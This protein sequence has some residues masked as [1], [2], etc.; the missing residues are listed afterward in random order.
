MNGRP[1]KRVRGKLRRLLGKRENG[2]VR[3]GPVVAPPRPDI[4]RSPRASRLGDRKQA[5][6][7]GGITAVND[8]VLLDEDGKLH[9]LNRINDE[10]NGAVASTQRGYQRREQTRAR[11][12]RRPSSA[13]RPP[14]GTLLDWRA[15]MPRWP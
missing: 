13:K 6:T 4:L 1:H 9:V 10:A 15:R 11:P 7:T 8:Q 12:R 3:S 5:R 14:G 2:C